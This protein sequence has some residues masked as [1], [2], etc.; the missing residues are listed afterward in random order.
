MRNL[1]VPVDH[2]NLRHEN[3]IYILANYYYLNLQMVAEM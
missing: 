2:I 3:A 1:S